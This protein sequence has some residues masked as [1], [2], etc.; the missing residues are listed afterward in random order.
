MAQNKSSSLTSVTAA[1]GVIIRKA[2]DQQAE[3]LLIFRR[4]VWDLPK[5]KLEDGETV[6][7]CAVREVTEEVGLADEPHIIGTS[8]ETYHEYEQE[9][10]HFGKTTHW[11]VMELASS[12]VSFKPEREEGIEKVKW[13]PLS[14]A[15]KKVGYDNLLTVLSGLN[16]ENYLSI[17][18]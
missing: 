15:K 6:E 2:E 9:G 17:S 3:V 4:G 10:I 18:S 13:Y 11:Y 7:E 8:S 12:Q 1:G 14:K 16:P 5:G